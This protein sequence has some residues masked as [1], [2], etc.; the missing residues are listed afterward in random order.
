MIRRSSNFALMTL[1]VFVGGLLIGCGA[2][3]DGNV[4]E[5]IEI[6]RVERGPLTV[7]ITAVGSVSPRADTALSFGAGGEVSDVL[8]RAGNRVR[9]GQELVQLDTNGLKLQVQSALAALAAAQAQLDQ[10][11]AGTRSEDIASARANL[12]AANARL[13]GAKA[14]LRALEKGPDENQIDSAEADL[15]AAQA[16]VDL[17][18]V[19]RDRLNEGP[20][21]AE[22]AAAQARLA[23]AQ[24]QQK[25]ARD[26][27]DE[28]LKCFDGVCP[29]LGTP[30][31]QARFN[32]YAADEAVAS[33]QAQLNQ[34]FAGP[35][36]GQIDEADVNSTAAQAQ[37]DAVQAQLDLLSSGSTAEM[38]QAAQAN[39]DALQAQGDAAKAQLDK[40]LAGTTAA[41]IA[42]AQAKVAQAQ[43][44]LD[45]AELALEKAV[46]RA[47][48]DGVV[49]RVDVEPGEFVA[50][51]APIVRLLDD[52]AFRIDVDV[53]EADIGWIEAGQ[54]VQL[55]LDSF[56]GQ[57]L[58][59]R[60]IGIDTSATLD[61]GVVSYG[62]T[63]ETG[64]ADL[65][66]RGGM[67]V[68]AEIVTD[69]REEALLVPN[70]AIW[71]DA[72]DGQ[73]FVERKQV[74]DIVRVKIEQG[75]AN[76]EYSEVLSGLDEGDTLVVRSGSVRER[77][78]E[79]MTG[80][81]GGQ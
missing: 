44:A 45:L 67:T 43:V 48:S 71:I 70:R 36:Q 62:V 1:F 2:S 18:L 9:T 3:A 51:Q 31:E 40:L 63:I 19:R 54:E 61:T 17:A 47:P 11:E 65:P 35:T 52:S 74:E 72:V 55:T 80:S 13:D 37:V 28:T 46:L 14:D 15:R 64:P 6:V 66:L 76:D 20:S 30:E 77:F 75:L 12:A 57:I 68:N 81:M 78:R 39:V 58:T 4:E 42:T 73:P 27:H 10:L 23:S 7:S 25:I 24:A 29:L 79:M 8:V 60:V 16:A 53:D 41:E 26:R 33:A 50:P 69:Q 34:L 56:P 38:L 5:Q 21:A 22:I 59:G 32:L 49:S